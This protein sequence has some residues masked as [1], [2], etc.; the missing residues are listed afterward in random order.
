MLGTVFVDDD[1]TVLLLELPLFDLN[2]PT[3]C[4]A[5]NKE[6]GDKQR[7][8]N[9]EAESSALKQNLG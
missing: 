5:A 9:A 4:Q 2:L 1:M 7:R 3:A 6:Q 8:T